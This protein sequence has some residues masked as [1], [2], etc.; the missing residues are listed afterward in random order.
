MVADNDNNDRAFGWPQGTVRGALAF[1]IMG[2]YSVGALC[3]TGGLAIRGH[4]AE[5]LAI[6][7][8]LSSMA[9]TVGG[10]YYGQKGSGS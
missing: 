8:G 4:F 1:L 10:F 7:A 5:A 9:G 6:F 2:S 3:L